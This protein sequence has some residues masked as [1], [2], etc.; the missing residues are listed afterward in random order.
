[1]PLEALAEA[2]DQQLQVGARVGVERREE[3]IGVDVRLGRRDGEGRTALELVPARARVELDEH[4]L[5]ARPRAERRGGVG[6]DRQLVVVDHVPVQVHRHDPDAVLGIDPGDLPD[7]DARDPHGLALTRDDRLGVGELGLELER[8]LLEERDV[9]ARLLLGDDVA[10]HANPD[11]EQHGEG[12]EVGEVLAD[13]ARHLPPPC[14]L[15]L[16]TGSPKLCTAP[17]YFAGSL[18]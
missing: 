8:R 12:D 14:D 16:P 3:L 9:R 11:R 1:M 5:Q 10:G 7:L 13:R 15:P 2:V 6:E 4:V 18:T 17:E